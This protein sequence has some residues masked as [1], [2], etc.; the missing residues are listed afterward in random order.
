MGMGQNP[1]HLIPAWLTIN[2]VHTFFWS[3]YLTPRYPGETEE[4]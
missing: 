4:S 1:E 2:A 3:I